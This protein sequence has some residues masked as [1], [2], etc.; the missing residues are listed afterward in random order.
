MASL[1]LV[2]PLRPV[3]VTV[4]VASDVDRQSLTIPTMSARRTLPLVE[5]VVG[6]MTLN[7]TLKLTMAKV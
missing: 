2:T 5:P 1:E 3:V 7:V 6:T 4:W